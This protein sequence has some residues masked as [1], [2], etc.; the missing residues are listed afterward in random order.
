MPEPNILLPF[1]DKS[2]H[3]LT[4]AVWNSLVA[5][6]GLDWETCLC[7]Q[8]TKITSLCCVSYFELAN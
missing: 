2:L 8:I 4:K 1:Q 5:H 7:L 3:F 6:A